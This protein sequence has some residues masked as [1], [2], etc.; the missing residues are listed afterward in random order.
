MRNEDDKRRR[1][2]KTTQVAMERRKLSEKY[3]KGGINGIRQPKRCG[4]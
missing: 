4:R 3:L 2:K 1:Q